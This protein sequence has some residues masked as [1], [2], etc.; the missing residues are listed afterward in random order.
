VALAVFTL[1]LGGIASALLRTP[2]S[3][4]KQG[5]ATGIDLRTAAKTRPFWLL[6]ASLVASCIGL[7]VPMVHL[8]PFAQD[9]GY[10]AAEG[11]TLVSLIGLGSLLG[12][13]TIGGVADRMGR[14]PSLVAMYAGLGAMLLLWWLA[15]SWWLL[16]LFALV[17]GAFYGGYVAVLPTIVMDLYG[18]RA[19]SGIL[20]WLYTGAGVG[21]LLGPWLAGVAFDSFGSYDVPI[22]VGALFSFIAAG[23]VVPLLGQGQ[24]LDRGQ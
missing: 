15:S 23:C 7:F 12:R 10:S 3:L 2:P 8:G 9:V 21:T 14:M 24:V 11:V 6:Y 5:S 20:G 13:F 19:V 22:L 16:A 1:L 17:F 18:A 4:K